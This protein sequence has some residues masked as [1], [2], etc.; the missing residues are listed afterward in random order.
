MMA[1][2]KRGIG[3]AV[4]LAGALLSGALPPAVAQQDRGVEVVTLPADAEGRWALV[5]GNAEYASGKLRNPRNDAADMAAMLGELGFAVDV[6]ENAG[7]QA[8]E[9]A[10]L[11]AFGIVP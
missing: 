10:I 7:H 4:V 6:L 5:V 2:S 1:T 9:D 11:R 3:S 8:M